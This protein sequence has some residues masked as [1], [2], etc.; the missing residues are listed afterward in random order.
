MAAQ[1]KFISLTGVAAHQPKVNFGGAL[2][3]W[4]ACAQAHSCGSL[5]GTL[6]WY[7]MWAELH[8]NAALITASLPYSTDLRI[9]S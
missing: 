8:S 2:T 4:T 6:A 9:D 7:Q 5:N 1:W 3:E